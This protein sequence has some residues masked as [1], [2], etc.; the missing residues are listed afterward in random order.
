MP[1][2]PMPF[3]VRSAA[4]VLVVFTLADIASLPARAQQK[5]PA[6]E[7]AEAASQALSRIMKALG[8][9]MQSIPQYEAPEIQPNGDILIRR[10]N[11]PAPKP[12]EPP[13]KGQT[14]T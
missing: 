12:A 9:V 14:N 11:T 2:P 4:A 5:S 10:K 7:A 6:D 3:L 1:L 8:S 13:P